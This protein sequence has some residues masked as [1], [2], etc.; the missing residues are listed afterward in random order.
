MCKRI[1]K[2]WIAP[3]VVWILCGCGDRE[4]PAPPAPAPAAEVE[5]PAAEAAEIPAEPTINPTIEP[6]PIPEPPAAPRSRSEALGFARHVPADAEALITIRNLASAIDG[7]KMMKLWG[8]AHNE[9]PDRPFQTPEMKDEDFSDLDGLLHEDD[10]FEH[11]PMISP[12]EVFGTEATLVLGKGGTERLAAWLS[13]N[14]RSAYH[15]MRGLA[16]SLSGKNN[17]DGTPFSPF[18]ALFGALNDPDLY[19][20]LI[21][22]AAAMRALDQFQIPPIYLAVRAEGERM[23]EVHEVMSEPVKSLANFNEMVTPVQV[24]RAGATFAGYRIIGAD[25]AA[26]LEDAGEYMEELFG[27]DVLQRIIEFLEPRE[28]VA[29]SG[30]V[31]DYSITFFGASVDDFNLAESPEHSIIHGDTLAFADSQLA[32]PL[33]ALVYAEKELLAT[34]T[35]N[36]TSLADLAMG[37][38]DGFAAHDRDGRNRD[39]T[40]LLQILSERHRALR[41]LT[42]HEATGI[43]LVN[44]GGP[45]IDTHGGTNGMLD[46]TPPSRFAALGDD[47]EVAIFLNVSIDARYSTRSTAYKEALFETTY[48]LLMRLMEAPEDGNQNDDDGFSFDPFAFIREYT[49]M[50]ENDFRGDFVNIW[51]AIARD[52]RNGL[53]RESAIIVDLQGTLPAVPGIPEALVD[54]ASSPRITYLAPVANRERL[55]AAW[56]KIHDGATRIT[57]HIGELQEREIPVPKPIRTEASGLSSWFLPYPVFD[58]EFLPSV[59]L[60]DSWFAMGTSRNQA[61]DLITRL[62][63]LEPRPGGGLHLKVNFHLL[64]SSQREQIATLRENRDAILE[65]EKIDADEFESTLETLESLAAGLEELETLESRCWQEGGITRSLIHLRVND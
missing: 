34:F 53:G 47:P 6:T 48:A 15:Q 22:D 59:T 38:R 30:I 50:F 36:S 1:A 2:W 18:T 11:S 54:K 20:L 29:L 64:A 27:T 44:D 55:R 9:I 23:H 58:D 4:K 52:M 41:A 32:Y 12:L 65:S 31:G 14:R 51:R 40:A 28:L 16:A 49:T 25:L 56:E 13:F 17:Q 7:V 21:Q 60:D 24:E 35:T 19:P 45:R 57:A 3:L 37:L 39:L 26:S 62:D 42:S 10:M 61:V 46:F 43:T 5:E 33:Y 63:T 8:A